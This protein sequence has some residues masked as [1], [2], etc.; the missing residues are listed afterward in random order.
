MEKTPR[1]QMKT[2]FGGLQSALDTTGER[3][4]EF[5]DRSIERNWRIKFRI[6]E[7]YLNSHIHS[8]IAYIANV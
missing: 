5:E 1:N 2:L 6:L 8:S 7:R 3:T 4:H